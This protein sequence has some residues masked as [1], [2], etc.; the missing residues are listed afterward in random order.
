MLLHEKGT[1]SM[2]GKETSIPDN[3][4]LSCPSSVTTAH[5]ECLGLGSSGVSLVFLPL[6]L[7]KLLEGGL[8]SE[9]TYT[10][11]GVEVGFAGNEVFSTVVLTCPDCHVQRSAEQLI[12]NWGS[13]GCAQEKHGQ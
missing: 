12:E 6:V 8:Y 7:W 3:V 1:L 11:L 2:L 5:L 4:G 13:G 10:V 9:K